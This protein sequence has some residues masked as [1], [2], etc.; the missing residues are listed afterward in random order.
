MNQLDNTHPAEKD[1]VWK[2]RAEGKESDAELLA[3][4]MLRVVG[5]KA[6]TLGTC[7][8]AEA[9]TLQLIQLSATF[10]PTE[11]SGGATATTLIIGRDMWKHR[12]VME[13]YLALDVVEKGI[14]Q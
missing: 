8:I 6:F 1:C 4:E 14:D 2:G 11:N 5:I 7:Q 10:Q 13:L 9:V 3:F 12:K